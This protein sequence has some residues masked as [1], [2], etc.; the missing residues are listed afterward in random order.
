MAIN[1][2][3]GGQI[4]RSSANLRGLLDYARHNPPSKVYVTQ[5]NQAGTGLVLF[6]D[7][8]TCRANFASYSIMLDWFDK[9]RSF[10]SAEFIIGS[11]A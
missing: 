3:K 2:I 5:L 10:K 9:R 7:G 11:K 6:K 1:I 8:A 4:I